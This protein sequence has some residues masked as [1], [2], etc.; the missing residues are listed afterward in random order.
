MAETVAD[1]VMAAKNADGRLPTINFSSSPSC[2]V[3]LRN[4]LLDRRRMLLGTSAMIGAAVAGCGAPEEQKPASPRPESRNVP[5]R[6]LLTGSARDAETMERGWGAIADHSLAIEAIDS[7]RDDA[8]A[9]SE[10][11]LSQAQKC[12][13]LIYPLM[14]ASD[15]EAS[16]S[17]TALSDAEVK[18]CD[19]G[20]ELYATLRAGAAIYSGKNIGIPLGASQ[21][22]IIAYDE[23]PDFGREQSLDWESYDDLVK[24]HWSGSAGEPTAPGY[25]GAMFLWRAASNTPWLFERETC[26]PL[27]DTEPYVETLTQMLTTHT[28]YKAKLET[29]EAIWDAV[30]EGK[31]QGGIGFPLIRSEANGEPAVIRNLPGVNNISRVLLDAFSPVASLSINCRQSTLAKQFIQWISGGEGSAATRNQIS[32]MTNIRAQV[33]QNDTSANSGSTPGYDRWLAEQ[34]TAPVNLPTLQIRQGGFY[35]QVLDQQ[36]RRTLQGEATP[37]EALAEVAAQWRAKNQEIGTDAQLRAWR[38]AQGMR[39]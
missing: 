21:P 1:Q 17:I 16:E 36:I 30:T 15:L 31:L 4:P 22:A 24:N 14:L 13:V 3:I 20:G 27:I 23:L 9:L 25:A 8:Q 5:L 10:Q 19:T 37:K 32:G 39:G 29:P 18:Q 2:F 35:Y 38:R 33:N 26:E 6:I 11:V 7:T 34:L 28:T 12:D